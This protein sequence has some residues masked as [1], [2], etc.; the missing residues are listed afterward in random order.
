MNN[1]NNSAGRDLMKKKGKRDMDMTRCY[2]VI[3][4]KTGYVSLS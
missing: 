3:V 4:G 2:F 1:E